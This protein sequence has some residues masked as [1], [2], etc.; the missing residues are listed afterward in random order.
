[1]LVPRRVDDSGV[2]PERNWNGDQMYNYLALGINIS[3]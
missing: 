3:Q 2:I 1:M